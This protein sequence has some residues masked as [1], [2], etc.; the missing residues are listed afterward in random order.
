VTARVI[1]IAG[2]SSGVGKTTVTLGLLEAF[3]RRGLRVQ[4]FK[5][6][7]DFIDPGFHAA[8]T[9]RPS[10][11][12]DGWMCTREHVVG[13]V[14][15]HASDADLAI[16]EGVMGCFDGTEGKNDEGSTA[17]VAKWLGAPVALVVDASALAR[18]AAAVVLGFERFDPDLALAAVILN[19]VAG[20]THARWLR[21][22]IESACRAAPVGFL[23]Q[24]EDLS[25][26]ERHLGLVTAL[27]HRLAPGFRDRLAAVI[28]QHVDLDRLLSLAAVVPAGHESIRSAHPGSPRS[29]A[30]TQRPTFRARI[31]VAYDRAFQ[32]YYA[33]NLDLLRAA[34]AEIV[35][36]SP[37]EDATLPDVGGLY[38]GGGYPEVHARRLAEN[39][40]ARAAV[41]RFAEAG[42]PIYAECGGLM[43]LAE[44]LEDSD[45]VE[46]AM[47]GVLPAAVRMRP[48]RLRLAYTE[49]ELIRAVPIGE[50]GSIARGHEF[51]CSTLDPVPAR[52]ER[53]YRVR[54][55]HAGD[56]EPEGYLV[57][58]TLMSYVHL[59]FGAAPSLADAFVKA[60]AS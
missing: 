50:A 29:G 22:A 20:E 40:A 21:D 5:V 26:P 57:G 4:A 60:C 25:L 11:N 28:E 39:E 24:C 9:G 56:A 27:E 52:I 45:G 46:H 36:W 59:H 13:S 48:G 44:R 32:F 12:L 37:L 33:E 16:V 10:Y 7:P 49:V 53:V 55:Q 35:S 23:P 14:A 47:V 31:G 41:R 19:R 2:V 42:R 1:V 54:R 43:Y 17:Q 3:R 30:A 18:S 15:R 58:R 8:V 34:G 51:H 6:G 38:L